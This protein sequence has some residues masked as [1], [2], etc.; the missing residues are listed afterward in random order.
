MIK[1]PLETE[2]FVIRRFEE[3]DLHPFLEFMVDEKSTGY[4]MLEPEQKTKEG[5][6]ALFNYVRSAYDS[7]EAIHSYA[8][9]EKR[10]NRY[11]GSCGY[12][13][14]DDGIVECYY[15]VNRADTGKGVAT[16]ATSALATAL[17]RQVEVRAYCHPENYAAHTVA[18]RSGF[19]PCGLQKHEQFGNTGLLFKYKG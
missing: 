10:T 5:A 7:D 9:A 1:T 17:S 13:S 16:E 14:Y 19:S 15:S 4:L 8:I 3:Q 11:V 12:A 18:K 2:N 6:T